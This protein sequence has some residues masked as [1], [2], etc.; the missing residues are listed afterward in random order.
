MSLREH[1][2]SVLLVSSSQVLISSLT[3]M[4]PESRFD[5]VTVVNSVNEAKRRLSERQYDFVIVNT[6][7][8]D[9]FGTGFAIE[10]CN[11]SRGTVVL[12]LV[13]AELYNEV[14]EKAAEYGVFILE[15][16]MSKFA[17]TT[18]VNWMISARERNRKAEIKSLSVEEKMEE[19]RL[20]NRAKW[21]LIKTEEMD[22][23]AA[24]RFIEKTAMDRCVSK[25]EVA[26]EII[27]K[28]R[29]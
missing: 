24:H 8:P 9:D 12:L 1:I 3:S 17:F 10:I 22:E 26:K 11:S 27:D 15:K 4:L 7:L 18:G 5:P 16:P 19:I 2:Y 28:D 20:V 13:R 23:S 14:Y 25:S 29:K 6:P 21:I